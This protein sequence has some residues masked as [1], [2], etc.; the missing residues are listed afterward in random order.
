MRSVLVVTLDRSGYLV[1]GL[2]VQ[3]VVIDDLTVDGRHWNLS[4]MRVEALLWFQI[5]IGGIL[6]YFGLFLSI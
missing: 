5:D 3:R 4:Q 2:D 1:L 6:T